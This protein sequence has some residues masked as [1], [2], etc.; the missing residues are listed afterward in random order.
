MSRYK[1]ELYD[2]GL[3]IYILCENNNCTLGYI[4]S[5]LFDKLKISRNRA[6]KEPFKQEGTSSFLFFFPIKWHDI[7]LPDFCLILFRLLQI[8][9]TEQS[10]SPC[11]VLKKDLRKRKKERRKVNRHEIAY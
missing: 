5:Y 4:I 11:Y 3:L 7:L 2:S 8:Y 1:I 6:R 9:C 10:K